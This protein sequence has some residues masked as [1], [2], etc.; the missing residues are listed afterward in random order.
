MRAVEFEGMVSASGE[1]A[2][3]PVIASSIPAGEHLRVVVMWGL[4]EQE[5]I[6]DAWRASG[7]RR[8]EAAYAPDDSIYEQLADEASPR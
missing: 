1:I 5:D 3:P 7:R 2:L 6:D 8:F 4:S